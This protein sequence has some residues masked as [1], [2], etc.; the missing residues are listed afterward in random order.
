MLYATLASIAFAIFIGLLPVL[1]ILRRMQYNESY[2]NSAKAC[3]S[4]ASWWVLL[5]AVFF[6]CVCISYFGAMRFWVSIL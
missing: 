1:F 6:I 5:L 4:S 2:W 3:A